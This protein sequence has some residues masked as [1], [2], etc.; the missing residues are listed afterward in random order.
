LT[1]TA[2]SNGSAA[3]TVQGT[4]ANIDAVVNGLT[5]APP[6]NLRFL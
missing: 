5:Y 1:F 6:S 4:L 3:M 2:G